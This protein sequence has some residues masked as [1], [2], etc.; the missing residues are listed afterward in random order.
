MKKESRGLCEENRE[1][2]LTESRINSDQAGR[3][4]TRKLC[5]QLSVITIL[6]NSRQVTHIFKVK[7]YRSQLCDILYCLSYFAF[8]KLNK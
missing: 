7:H 8:L 1:K 5:H 2:T 4:G 3:Q 6:L